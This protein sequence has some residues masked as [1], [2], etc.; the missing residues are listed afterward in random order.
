MIQR[1]AEE[2]GIGEANG[3]NGLGTMESV[4]EEDSENETTKKSSVVSKNRQTEQPLLDNNTSSKK[5]TR[6]S[7]DKT[8]QK[9]QSQSIQSKPRSSLQSIASSL[10]SVFDFF[11]REQWEAPASPAAAVQVHAALVEANVTL[12]QARREGKVAR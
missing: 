7:K 6:D 9:N 10:A 2:D 11:T 3:T 5:N 1:I 4:D 8:L 12:E